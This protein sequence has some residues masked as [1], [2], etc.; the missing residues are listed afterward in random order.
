MLRDHKIVE[1]DRATRTYRLLGYEKLSAEEQNVLKELCQKR[2]D[3]FIEA[4]GRAIYDHRRVS[5]GYI[6]G[7]LK[8]SDPKIRYSPISS[9]H[10]KKVPGRLSRNLLFSGDDFT[11]PA[12]ANQEKSSPDPCRRSCLSKGL[13]A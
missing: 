10:K 7:R 5:V 3:A 1:R 12:R 4:R 2:L 11:G 6:S 9:C 13:P 8:Y